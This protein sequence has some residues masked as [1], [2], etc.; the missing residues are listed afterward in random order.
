MPLTGDGE[1]IPVVQSGFKDNWARFSPDGKWVS[2]TSNES[3][4]EEVYVVPFP[5]PGGKWQ[6]STGGGNQG[7]W[8]PDGTEIFY[9]APDDQFMVAPVSPGDSTFQVGS[10]RPLTKLQSQALGRKYSV[11]PDGQKFLMNI[12]GEI[13]TISPITLV[14]NWTEDLKDK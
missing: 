13:G 1:P 6:I 11:S 14:V 7:Q 8:N 10:V 2:Y 3:G 4:R 12:T 5:G 9:I